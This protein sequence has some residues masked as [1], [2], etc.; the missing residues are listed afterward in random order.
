MECQD[1]KVLARLQTSST[2]ECI[3]RLTKSIEGELLV[4][5]VLHALVQIHFCFVLYT[6]YRNAGLTKTE[7][8]VGGSNDEN[9]VIDDV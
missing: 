8:G 7:G 1:S 4:F 9:G 5:I 3:S 2:E 6:H